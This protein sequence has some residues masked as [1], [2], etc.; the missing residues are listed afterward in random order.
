MPKGRNPLNVFKKKVQPLFNDPLGEAPTKGRS[1]RGITLK[2][3]PRLGGIWTK[4][5]PRYC[6]PLCPSV[7]LSTPRAH[8]RIYP[9]YYAFE[10][11]LPL[12]PLLEYRSTIDPLRACAIAV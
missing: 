6:T 5:G 7:P 11:S 2:M 12:D 9:L 10:V 3:E 1:V 8:I 4:V